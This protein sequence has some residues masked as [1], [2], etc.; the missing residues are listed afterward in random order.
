MFDIGDPIIFGTVAVLGQFPNPPPEIARF[1]EDELFPDGPPPIRLPTLERLAWD[2]EVRERSGAVDDDTDQ[3]EIEADKERIMNLPVGWDERLITV[4][5][6]G[7]CG[8]TGWCLEVH[9]LA[10]SKLVAGGENDLHFVSL[11]ARENMIAVETLLERIDL[12][13]L[14]EDRQASIR[15]RWQTLLHSG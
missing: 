11:L 12:L 1:I 13:L 9:D 10:A 3:R 7:T 2:A 14:P 4:R 5:G 15:Q 6:E 8:A